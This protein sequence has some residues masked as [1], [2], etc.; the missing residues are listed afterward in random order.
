MPSGRSCRMQKNAL[1]TH[2]QSPGQI[3]SDLF[4]LCW[5]DGIAFATS[6]AFRV[7]PFIPIDCASGDIFFLPPPLRCAAGPRSFRIDFQIQI[8]EFVL[9]ILLF[10]S[11]VRIILLGARDAAVSIRARAPR[12]PFPR[13]RQPNLVRAAH[14]HGQ[15]PIRK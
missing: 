5:R 14:Q 11:I 4:Y 8:T 12:P 6:T 10:I 1:L 7:S 2:S 15:R 13:F 9:H 3:S